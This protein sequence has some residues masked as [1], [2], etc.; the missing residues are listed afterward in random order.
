MS[1][2]LRIYI[3][4]DSREIDLCPVLVAALQERDGDPG[5]SP[6]R[7]DGQRTRA[8]SCEGLFRLEGAQGDL[9][10]VYKYLKGGCKKTSQA[11]FRGA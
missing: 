3:Y 7:R 10:N 8:L 6:V 4:E 11:V 1:M 9:I 5:E 2:Y